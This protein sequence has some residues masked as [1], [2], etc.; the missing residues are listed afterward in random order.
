MLDL[1]PNQIQ[2]KY[3]DFDFFVEGACLELIEK[4]QIQFQIRMSRIGQDCGHDLKIFLFL[5]SLFSCHLM[6]QQYLTEQLELTDLPDALLLRSLKIFEMHNS[7]H[8]GT[9]S[10]P[11]RPGHLEK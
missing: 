4:Y 11:D 7:F 2:M 1:S 8:K 3:F 5:V 6:I 10:S 9:W